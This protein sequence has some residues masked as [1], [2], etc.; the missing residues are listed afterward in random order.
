MSDEI[1]ESL[2]RRYTRAQLIRAALLTYP[3]PARSQAVLD[4]ADTAGVAVFW[5]DR[6]TFEAS[7][8]IV[9][10]DAEWS[11]VRSELGNFD[12][13]VS[14]GHGISDSVRGW[15]EDCIAS[16]GLDLETLEARWAREAIGRG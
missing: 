2:V 5:Q 6:S 11:E 7:L 3:P 12:E 9:F 13:H 14:N 16:A 8:C 4:V 10:T 15:M 1:E